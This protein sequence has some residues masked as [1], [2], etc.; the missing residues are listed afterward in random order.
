MRLHIVTGH[1]HT[2]SFCLPRIW[3]EKSEHSDFFFFLPFAFM[4][5]RHT[6]IKQLRTGI[7]AREQFPGQILDLSTDSAPHH[8]PSARMIA[9][10]G[11][12]AFPCL[13]QSSPIAAQHGQNLLS[14]ETP[15]REDSGPPFP[16][17]LLGPV[18]L[19]R[20]HL[21]TPLLGSPPGQC[22]PAPVHPG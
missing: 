20:S 15:L 17:T 5:E 8:S 10:Q 11:A 16:Y 7:R 13:A 12:V 2:A 14:P 9:I 1:T 21:R 6:E 3:T 4:R 18:W 19:L 22:V